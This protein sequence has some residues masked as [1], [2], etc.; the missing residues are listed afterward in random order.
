MLGTILA[1]WHLQK[2]PLP[3]NYLELFVLGVFAIM[4]IAGVFLLKKFK[5]KQPAFIYLI[6]TLIFAERLVHINLIRLA[7]SQPPSFRHFFQS[8]LFERFRPINKYD[9]RI[10]FI[11]WHPTVGLYNGY[12]VAGGYASQYLRRYAIF[13][14]SV[15][16]GEK[17]EFFSYPYKA[18]L[19]D[20]DVERETHPPGIIKR[21]TFNPELLALHNV[22]Y[23]FSFNEIGT[24]ERWGLSLA[25]KGQAPDR[26]LGWGRYLQTFRRIFEPISY[27]VYEIDDYLPRVFLSSNFILSEDESAMKEVMQKSNR[28]EL[29][30]KVIYNKKDLNLSQIDLLSSVKADN[31][32]RGLDKGKIVYYSDNKIVVEVAAE[33]IQQLVLL[34]NYSNEWVA[35]IDGNQTQILPA[36]GVF[37]SVVIEKGRHKVTFEYKPAYLIKSLW[38]S[39]L[40]TILFIGFGVAW[41]LAS[42]KTKKG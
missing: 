3:S 41:F 8:E 4:F 26:V 9:Y 6:I 34:E 13:W 1:I 36:Y 5:A 2:H 7:D 35:E 30:Y 38:I 11:N 20:K 18:Y 39:G 42:G 14:E 22:R 10:A 29:K 24:P 31:Y 16:P 21:I 28:K 40:G 15:L 27:Y 25:H 37:R 23:I 17:G 32:L 12:Q 33:S 19:I